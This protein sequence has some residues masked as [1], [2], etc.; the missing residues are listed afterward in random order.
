[1]VRSVV[2]MLSSCLSKLSKLGL[3][4]AAVGKPSFQG[5]RRSGLCSPG[6]SVDQYGSSSSSQLSSLFLAAMSAIRIAKALSE[7]YFWVG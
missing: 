4:V 5:N 6:S 3:A 1:M 7:L 2:F